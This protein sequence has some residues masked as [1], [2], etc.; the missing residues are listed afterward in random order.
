MLISI[1]ITVSIKYRY[2]SIIDNK[3]YY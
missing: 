2:M 3:E 1:D